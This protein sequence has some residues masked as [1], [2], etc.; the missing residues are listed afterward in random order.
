MVAGVDT[1]SNGMSR[2]LD[3]LAQHPDV[4]E[5]LCAEVFEA[6]ERYGK[7]IPFDDI[8]QLPYLDAICRETLRLYVSSIFAR[9]VR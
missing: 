7:E 5:R 8:M 4:Q 1:T 6:R 2:V 3:L 9:A